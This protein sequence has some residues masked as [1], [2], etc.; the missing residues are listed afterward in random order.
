MQQ[1]CFYIQFFCCIHAQVISARTV[2]STGN[3]DFNVTHLECKFVVLFCS[4]T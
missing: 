2:L 1:M 3:N 4:I